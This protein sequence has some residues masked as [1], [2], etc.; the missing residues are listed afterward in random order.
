MYAWVISCG[1]LL[2]KHVVIGRTII[3]GRIAYT[4]L[5]FCML[6]FFMCLRSSSVGTDTENYA[7]NIYPFIAN[8]SFVDL[9][10]TVEFN[11][12]P[13]YWLVL[14]VVGQISDAP[15]M[16]IMATS[17]IFLLGAAFFI[18]KTSTNIVASMVL[19]LGLDIYS[20]GFNATKQSISMI[21]AANAFWL[22]YKSHRSV[23]GWCLLLIAI[24]THFSTGVFI[25][26][27]LL[28]LLSK[29]V[30]TKTLVLFSVLSSALVIIGVDVAFQF[31]IQYVEAY[32]FYDMANNPFAMNAASSEY[33]IG[34]WFKAAGFIAVW[35]IYAIKLMRHSKEEKFNLAYAIFPTVIMYAGLSVIF[36]EYISLSRMI[37]SMQ[38]LMIIF[39]PA[40]IQNCPKFSR[41]ILY[42]IMGI[43]MILYSSW[44]MYLGGHGIFPYSFCD[45]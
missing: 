35:L 11:K 12:A 24:G 42:G 36:R 34:V 25:I 33:G 21:V 32:S 5:S 20:M 13:V 4:M 28:M 43:G 8:C 39:I 41:Q 15:Q 7:V 45:F 23:K 38:T 14:W 16:Y 19:F 10:D 44:G 31:F 2:N 37:L 22:L 18:Y 40:V 9:A 26:P 6:A 29:K 30:S 1:Y 27:V 17:V 3:D